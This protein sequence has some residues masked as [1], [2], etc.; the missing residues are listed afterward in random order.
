V[1]NAARLNRTGFLGKCMGGT[2]WNNVLKSCDQPMYV[3]DCNPSVDCD[4][5]SRTTGLCPSPQPTATTCCVGQNVNRGEPGFLPIFTSGDAENEYSVDD[6]PIQKCPLGQIFRV[7]TCCCEFVYVQDT[8][9][10]DTTSFYFSN[11]EDPC[12]SFLQCWSNR[13][14][15]DVVKCMPPSVW[16]DVNKT[17]DT[18]DNVI[19]CSDA[20][21]GVEM[22]DPPCDENSAAACCRAGIYYDNVDGE[23]TRYIIAD[24]PDGPSDRFST[25]PE[26][27]NGVQLVFNGD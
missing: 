27:M 6:G 7:E 10:A 3:P 21:C 5:P 26:D 15:Y 19:E 25:C 22:T 2:A 12:C 24:G 17:C 20:I 8:E 16:N 23:P 13:T 4:V 14:G 11:P 1:C 18:T 9:C